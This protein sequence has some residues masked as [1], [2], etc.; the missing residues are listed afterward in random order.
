[1]VKVK[2]LCCIHFVMAMSSKKLVGL[3]KL[4][5]LARTEMCKIVNANLSK[6]EWR[7]TVEE[8][9]MEKHGKKNTK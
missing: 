8:Y 6:V 7:F 2:T 9:V 3:E 5:F 4:Y 1:M